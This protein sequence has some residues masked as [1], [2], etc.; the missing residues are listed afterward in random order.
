MLDRQ[1]STA[2]P[3][4]AIVFISASGSVSDAMSTPWPIRSACA[5]STARR[6]WNVLWFEPAGRYFGTTSP[7][8]SVMW[9]GLF[10]VSVYLVCRKSIIAMCRS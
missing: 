4:A 9:S 1:T 10:C 7:A 8:W 6:T 5:T 3:F 2:T